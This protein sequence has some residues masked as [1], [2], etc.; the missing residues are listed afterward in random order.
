MRKIGEKIAVVI[1]GRVRD[2]IVSALTDRK[3]DIGISE[4]TV[5]LPVW[6]DEMI[7]TG[8]REKNN[9]RGARRWGVTEEAPVQKEYRLR[10]GGGN[11]GKRRGR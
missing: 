6:A 1:N 5:T 11:P 2:G 10:L 3:D 9:T 8:E 7:P 4:Y